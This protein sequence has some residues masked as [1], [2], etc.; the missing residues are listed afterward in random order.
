[1]PPARLYEEIVKLF[2]A[3]AGHRSY[4]RLR[5]YGLLGHLCPETDARIAAGKPFTPGFLF[6]ALLWEPV[7]HESEVCTARGMSDLQAYDAAGTDVTER[8]IQHVSL[9]CRFSHMVRELWALQ[10]R[11]VNWRGR[12]AASPLLAHPRFRVA[13]D[14]LLPRAE[15]GEDVA[16]HAQWWTRLQEAEDGE[17][18]SM[19]EDRRGRKN[20]GADAAAPY[21]RSRRESPRCELAVP[22]GRACPLGPSRRTAKPGR[23]VGRDDGR[24]RYPL[25]GG[26][27]PE[28]SGQDH[29]RE[30][31]EENPFLARFYETPPMNALATQPLFLI[32]RVRQLEDIRQSDLFATVRVGDFMI[33]KER[34]FAEL[35]LYR[36]VYERIAGEAVAPVDVLLGRIA[37][38]AIPYEAFMDPRYLEHVASAYTRFFHHYEGA[39]HVIVN[40]A[41]IDFAYVD[42]DYEHLFDKVHSISKGRDYPNPLP[43]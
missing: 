14:F 13:Y 12:G 43:L 40:A 37:E 32:Q 27:R 42:A 26:R 21:A 4:E 2:M 23:R 39:P 35:A 41:E 8:Q 36:Q 31:P 11:L 7:L 38:R 16:E 22:C 19:L 18:R 30:T 17:R 25:H 10:P 34:L 24:I 5:R 20:D 28:R 33:E 1:M 29:A 3:G 6:A 9:P 15:S